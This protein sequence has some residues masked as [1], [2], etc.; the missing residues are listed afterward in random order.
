MV[1][2]FDDPDDAEHDGACTLASPQKSGVVPM[3]RFSVNAAQKGTNL[4]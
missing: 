1:L 4:H 2:L 3:A